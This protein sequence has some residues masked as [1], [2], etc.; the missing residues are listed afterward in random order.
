[1][2]GV[3]HGRQRATK[4]VTRVGRIV[5]GAGEG[6]VVVASGDARVGGPGQIVLV[7]GVLDVG[8][9]LRA[10]A[11]E[12]EA[13]AQEV[14][15]G[16]SSVCTRRGRG[17][18]IGLRL[19]SDNVPQSGRFLN[20]ARSLPCRR[21]A[22]PLESSYR[23]AILSRS[24]NWSSHAERTDQ[25]FSSMGQ[26][27][28][29]C[30]GRSVRRAAHVVGSWHPRR[31]PWRKA[32]I[33]CVH[34]QQLAVPVQPHGHRGQLRCWSFGGAVT[35]FNRRDAAAS[36]SAHRRMDRERGAP[37]PRSCRTS[38]RRRLRPN[39]VAHVPRGRH[40]IWRC[41]LAGTCTCVQ[42]AETRFPGEPLIGPLLRAVPSARRQRPPLPLP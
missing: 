32:A 39:L 20:R 34:V 35:S 18:D 21:N 10:L 15:G 42:D 23:R 16:I 29:L 5:E 31:L 3:P 12:I 13:A 26:L 33:S 7:D 9:E 8:E 2:L 28:R 14:V 40:S 11:V 24:S 1:M 41:R 19:V 30:V 38:G 27:R 22:N 17:R 25:P 37:P 36:G 4:V 6:E